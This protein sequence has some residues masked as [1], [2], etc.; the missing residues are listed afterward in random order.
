MQTKKI[1]ES[2]SA[3][4]RLIAAMAFMDFEGVAM[5]QVSRKEDPDGMEACCLRGGKGN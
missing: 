1:L 5:F 2:N 3:G 4:M